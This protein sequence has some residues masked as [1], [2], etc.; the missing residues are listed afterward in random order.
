[1]F[2]GTN[3]IKYFLKIGNP[4]KS[5]AQVQ[6]SAKHFLDRVTKEDTSKTIFDKKLN[7]RQLF[8]PYYN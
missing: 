8:R 7:P 3:Y 5:L 6:S 4:A 1:M 2:I